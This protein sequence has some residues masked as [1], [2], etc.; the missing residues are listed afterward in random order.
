MQRFY[1]SRARNY[2]SKETRVH[3][4]E[5]EEKE[6]TGNRKE[7]VHQAKETKDKVSE[8]L[9]KEV[10]LNNVLKTK[11]I[12]SVKTGNTNQIESMN[13]VDTNLI[14]QVNVGNTDQIDEVVEG[15]T[16][17]DVRDTEYVDKDQVTAE[18]YQGTAEGFQGTPDEFQ[19]IAEEYQGTAEEYQGTAEEYQETAEEYQETAEEFQ[20]IIEGL[21]VNAKETEQETEKK[22]IYDIRDELEYEKYKPTLSTGRIEKKIPIAHKMLR[23]PINYAKVRVLNAAG[24]CDKINVA[25]GDRTFVSNL[26]YGKVSAYDRVIDGYKTLVVYINRSPQEPLLITNIPFI[27]G[28]SMT[29]VVVDTARGLQLVPILDTVCSTHIYD[30]ACFRVANLTYDDGPFDILLND[31]TMIFSDINVKEVTTFKQAV[32][33]DYDFNIVL[34]NNNV[35]NFYVKIAPKMKYTACIIGGHFLN[36]PLK[37]III[38]N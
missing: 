20:A 25:I 38:E 5:I 32:T 17:L 7:I 15:S 10:E 9:T 26:S 8:A 2:S 13:S 30:R 35:L 14:N 16:I 4:A 33:G 23:N 34:G 37:V 22:L 6:D 29:L 31:N 36:R 12:D 27:A 18:E 11:E 24:D 19:V 28:M 21:K 1:G 3:V